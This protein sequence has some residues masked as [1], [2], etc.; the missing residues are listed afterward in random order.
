MTSR[1]ISKADSF[2]IVH[3]QKPQTVL[4]SVLKNVVGRNL[5][6][7]ARTK[8]ATPTGPTAT[9]DK[10]TKKCYSPLFKPINRQ[11]GNIFKKKKLYTH[12]TDTEWSIYKRSHDHV[13]TLSFLHSSETS[14]QLPKMSR[15]IHVSEALYCSSIRHTAV[16][17]MVSATDGSQAEE[18]KNNLL[19]PT[20]ETMTVLA[21]VCCRDTIRNEESSHC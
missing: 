16:R 11:T 2:I 4:I 14:V 19:M 1:L 18:R 6:L 13:T 9:S 12:E 20:A 7:N 3:R 5:S 17:E 8:N 10:L 21:V 15:K